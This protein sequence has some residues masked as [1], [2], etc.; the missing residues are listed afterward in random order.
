MIAAP[1][2]TKLLIASNTG[3][4]IGKMTTEAS[5]LLA[6]VIWSRATVEGPWTNIFQADHPPTDWAILRRGLS[7]CDTTLSML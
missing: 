7:T 1:R 4:A 6:V 5:S 2:Y 3:T